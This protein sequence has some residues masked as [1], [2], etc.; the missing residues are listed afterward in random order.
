[1]EGQLIVGA[2]R[3]YFHVTVLDTVD[4][5]PQPSFAVN[6]L[7]CDFKQSPVIVPSLGVTVGAPHASV[8]VA[9]PNAASMALVPGFHSS[10]NVVPPDISVGAVTSYIHLTVREVVDVLRHPSVAVN[11]LVLERL[12]PLLTT[13]PSDDVI[14]TAPQTSVAVAVLSEPSGFAGLQLRFT[15]A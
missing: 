1:M 3:S 15:S 12:H 13:A 4:V 2:V 10:V 9:V 6:V 8:A 11:V 14:V 7:V 5:L